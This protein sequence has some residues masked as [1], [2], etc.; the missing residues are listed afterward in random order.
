M[1]YEHLKEKNELI[2]KGNSYFLILAVGTVI[3]AGF[4]IRVLFGLLPFEDGYTFGNIFGFAFICVWVLGVLSMGF[5]SLEAYS[6]KI[7]IN[8]EGVLASSWFR[9]K[10]FKWDDIKDWGLSYCGQTK[11]EGNTYYLYFA[12]QVCTAK[13]D[14]KKK[15]KG[16]MLKT[17]VIGE[18]YKEAFDVIIPFCAEKTDVKPFIAKDKYHFI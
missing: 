10:L 15:L 2:I 1:M 11:G 8:S 4:G 14:C 9:K 3:M 6:K 7:I 16:K 13:N 5:Y 18:D 12:K 17:F